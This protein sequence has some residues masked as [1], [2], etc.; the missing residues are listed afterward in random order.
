MRKAPPDNLIA[1]PLFRDRPMEKQELPDFVAAYQGRHPG[2]RLPRKLDLGTQKFLLQHEVRPLREDAPRCLILQS[3]PGVGKSEGCLEAVTRRGWNG[4]VQSSSTFLGETEMS[5]LA[6]LNLEFE[7]AVRISA[8]TGRPTCLIFDDIDLILGADAHEVRGPAHRVISE[9]VMYLASNKH[10]YC[11]TDGSPV[12]FIG[13]GNNFVGVR[14]SVF[15]DGRAT[16]ETVVVE[17]DEQ[18]DMV[19]R[20]FRATEPQDFETLAAFTG[21]NG[22]ETISFFVAVKS[23]LETERLN[24]MLIEGWP[25]ERIEA[26]FAEGTPVDLTALRSAA[27]KLRANRATDFIKQ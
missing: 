18:A 8:E 6:N 22:V 15:R 11:N 21:E 5:G 16:W 9:R 23:A 3:L 25:M 26:A 20:L 24:Q 12:P 2:W 19:A 14:S 1:M 27:E 17:P 4:R 7:H 10:V 13:T